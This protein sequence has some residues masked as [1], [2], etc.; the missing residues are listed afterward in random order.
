MQPANTGK[1]DMFGKDAP[2]WG[3][4]HKFGGVAN[5][6]HADGSANV[7]ETYPVLVI[8]ALG[9][10]L[11]DDSR[12]TGRLPKYN[13]DRRKT[14][15]ESDWKYLCCKVRKQLQ[16]F[17]LHDLSDWVAS[18][19]NTVNLGK[20]TQDNLDACICLIAGLYMVCE[21]N[22][23]VIGDMDTGYIVSPYSAKLSSE[24]KTRCAKIN[25]EHIKWLY[26]PKHLA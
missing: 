13:P 7:F 24:L 23:M 17:G 8:I 11:P 21:E 15:S 2:V 25:R 10:L 3:F 16:E 18:V 9:W 6:Y 14:F 12:S 20:H 19:T 1:A 5:P 22:F 26:Y 4:L